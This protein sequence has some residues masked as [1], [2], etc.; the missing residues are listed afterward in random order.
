[1]P[2]T[3]ETVRRIAELA[4]I[5]LTEEELAPMALELDSIVHWL[6][7]LKEVDVSD[8]DLQ[9]S[10]KESLRERE[11]VAEPAPPTDDILSNA[12]DSAAPWFA[13]PKFIG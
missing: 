7:L 10:L 9:S 5:R 8:I 4:S 6:A 2:V 1:M 3:V 12:P 11:D 13:V